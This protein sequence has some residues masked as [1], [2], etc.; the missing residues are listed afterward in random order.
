MF[1]TV[2]ADDG[3]GVKQEDAGG[4]EFFFEGVRSDTGWERNFK[5]YGKDG[6]RNNRSLDFFSQGI[7]L[8]SKNK[9]AFL[10]FFLDFSLVKGEE[11]SVRKKK[12]F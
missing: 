10:S 3:V 1:V 2:E 9:S 6:V 11:N 8:S 4:F 5:R 7:A 12:E